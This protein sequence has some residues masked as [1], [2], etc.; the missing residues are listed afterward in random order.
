M[1]TESQC[2]GLYLPPEKEKHGHKKVCTRMYLT[3]LFI[4]AQI[5]N[6]PDV[7]TGE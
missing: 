5:W 3:A 6:Q 7:S 4:I 2:L 1:T